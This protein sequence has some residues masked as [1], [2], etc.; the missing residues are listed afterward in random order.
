MSAAGARDDDL[1][2]VVCG[3]RQ[4]G[5]PREGV[6]MTE[7][8]PR[9]DF[10]DDEDALFA[11]VADLPEQ[12]LRV[13][14]AQANAALTMTYWLVGRAISMNLLRKQRADYG[15]QIYATLSRKLTAMFGRGFEVGSL[16]RMVQFAEA[17]CFPAGTCGADGSL[18]EVARCLR[19]RARGGGTHRV[20]LCSEADREEVEFL[21][22]H[23][24]GIAV[25]E[26]WTTLPP[27]A[28]LES[29]L[30]QIV[31]DAQERLARR[32]IA[33]ELESDSTDD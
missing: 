21:E 9:D 6:G 23:K 33:E 25:V 15:K 2:V 20:D 30:R 13:A 12:G 11:Y 29:K 14:A 4:A 1:P 32:G 17:R 10:P 18:L 3:V 28:A 26:Y 27:K 19:A 8:V 24:D 16:R 7:L 22:L 31:R 5:Q